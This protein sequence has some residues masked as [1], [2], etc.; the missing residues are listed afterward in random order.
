MKFIRRHD[1]TPHTR[2]EMVRLAWLNQGIYGKMTQIAQEYHI[3]R[4]WLSQLIWA[5]NLQLETLFS[6]QKPHAQDSQILFEPLILLLRLEGK[7]SL[8]SLSSILKYF[9]YQPNSVGY[10]S[11]CFQHYGAALPSTLA[12]VERTVVFYLSDE[13]FARHQPILVT[14]EAQSTAILK[15]QLASDRSAETWK[16]HFDA[17]GDHRFH[18]IGMASDRGLGLMAGYHAACPD[19]RW[20]CDRFHEFQDLFDRRRQLERKAYA[21]IAKEDEAAHMFHHAKS[22]ANLAKRLQHYE[23]AHHACEH[24]MARYDQLDLLLHLLRDALHLCSPWGRL[25]TVAG[26]RAELTLLLSLIA[27][28]DDAV[29]PKLLHTLHAHLDDILVPFE[30]AES[31]HI[32]L[33]DL[34]PQQIL[35]ALVLAWHHAHLSYQSSA[36][37][38]R[39]HQHESQQWLAF[40]EGLL[41]HQFT[42]LQAVVFEKLD[43]IVQASSLVELVNSFIRPYLNSSK[44]QITQETLNLIMFYHNHRRYKSG[45]RQG[46]API[47]LLTGEALKADWVALLLQHTQEPSPC[48]SLIPSAPLTLVPPGHEHTTSSQTPPGQV[49]LEPSTESAIPWSPMDAEAA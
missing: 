48:P 42:P 8:P 28:I 22:E 19:A 35:D 15:I 45:K 9:Q 32:A 43:A 25:R 41:E 1:L 12:M 37:Q 3:S 49:L 31:L 40:A 36:K 20:V 26:V 16:A 38:K 5:A 14:I 47:E 46:K 11:E 44:G 24:A 4:T 10:L 29:L 27:E 2:I 13:I 23:R 30:Q 7:C 39:Y 18:S 33:L 17:L 6:E 34:V 21:A